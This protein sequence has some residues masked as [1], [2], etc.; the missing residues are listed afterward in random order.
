VVAR[1]AGSHRAGW[2]P[3]PPAEPDVQWRVSGEIHIDWFSRWPLFMPRFFDQED[4]ALA[5]ATAELARIWRRPLASTARYS[6]RYS[7][8]LQVGRHVGDR[9]I[10]CRSVGTIGMDHATGK[11][12]WGYR[13]RLRRRWALGPNM[14][15][16]AHGGRA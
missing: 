9:W 16:P 10:P 12:V 13:A 3:L 11:I 5:A 14:T 4:A 15:R 1:H 8:Q 2:T 6:L 7:V